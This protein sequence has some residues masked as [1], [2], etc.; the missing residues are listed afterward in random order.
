[1]GQGGWNEVIFRIHS[2]PSHSVVLCDS[3]KV[4]STRVSCQADETPLRLE[5][6]NLLLSTLAR[7][8]TKAPASLFISI[9]SGP[10]FV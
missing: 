7:L 1:M 6:K 5:N 2:N 8:Q 9:L 4:Q 3:V 10:L